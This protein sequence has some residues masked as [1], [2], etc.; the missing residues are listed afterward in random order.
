MEIMKR[1]REDIKKDQNSL[2]KMKSFFSC[3]ID[4]LVTFAFDACIFGVKSK[5]NIA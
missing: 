1:E 4:P 5:N 3:A 2:F